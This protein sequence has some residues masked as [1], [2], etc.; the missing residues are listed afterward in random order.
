MATS[1][2]MRIQGQIRAALDGLLQDARAYSRDPAAVERAA[3]FLLFKLWAA[4]YAREAI[5]RTIQF[6]QSLE[7]AFPVG[8]ITVETQDQQALDRLHLFQDLYL[9]ELTGVADALAQLA[10][11]LRPLKSS[12]RSPHAEQK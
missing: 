2:R 9:V 3:K 8:P 6:P 7:P 12:T 10:P 4:G 1:G 11:D 5:M